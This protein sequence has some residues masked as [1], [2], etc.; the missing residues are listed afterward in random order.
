M[1]VSFGISNIQQGIGFAA[2]I[3]VTKSIIDTLSIFTEANY[4]DYGSV[5]FLGVSNF[6]ANY[7]HSAHI[8]SYDA[9]VGVS[10]KIA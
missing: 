4:H 6:S 7:S 9:V 8:Y 2:G 5:S 10:Y 1:T 3:G